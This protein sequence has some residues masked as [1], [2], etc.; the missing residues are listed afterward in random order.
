MSACFSML[1]NAGFLLEQPSNR[2]GV[3]QDLMNIYIA[4]GV[5]L[6]C[7][8]QFGCS[9][10]DAE[11]DSQKA[12]A[13]AKARSEAARKEMDTLPKQFQSPDYFKKNDL[14]KKSE[15]AASDAHSPPA[16]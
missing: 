5:L 10:R 12:A 1:K 16:K 13:E 15:S 4:V 3:V 14:K 7:S 8:S 9:K 11:Q 2:K 6:V